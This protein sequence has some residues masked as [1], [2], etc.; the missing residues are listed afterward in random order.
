MKQNS[1]FQ[2]KATLQDIEPAIWRRIQVSEACTFW[3]LHVAIQDA[4]G[5]K[6]CHLHHFEVIDHNTG[7]KIF[8]GIPKDDG[9]DDEQTLSGWDYRVIDYVTENHQM[10]YLID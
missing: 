2:F 9:F 8:M 6:D 5:W 3:D 1:V 10:I 4:M 7:E